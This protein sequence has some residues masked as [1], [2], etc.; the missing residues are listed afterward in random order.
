MDS[1]TTSLGDRCDGVE[2]A[3]RPLTWGQFKL[4]AEAL[5]VKDETLIE[6]IELPLVSTG[7]FMVMLK[8]R[9]DG[10]SSVAIKG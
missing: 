8:P 5:G 2:I 10:T 6:S 9:G 7:D 3:T 4:D 1:E